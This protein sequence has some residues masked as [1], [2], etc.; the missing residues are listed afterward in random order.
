[1]AIH[2]L[3][4]L[5]GVFARDA[6]RPV[7]VDYCLSHLDGDKVAIVSSLLDYPSNDLSLASLL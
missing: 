3:C 5:L 4:V 1:M 6:L 2:L 7:L